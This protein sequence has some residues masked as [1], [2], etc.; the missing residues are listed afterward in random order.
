MTSSKFTDRR[1]K[2]KWP[3]NFLSSASILNSSLETFSYDPNPILCAAF[4]FRIYR[5]PLR[6]RLR[7]RL[8]LAQ[9]DDY[10]SAASSPFFTFSTTVLNAKP[11]FGSASIK[12]LRSAIGPRASY[13]LSSSGD[14]CK[15]PASF[16][17]ISS[18][19][20]RLPSSMSERKGLEMSIWSRQFAQG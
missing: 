9:L 20:K 18:E 7:S 19:G 1:T 14:T 3:R 4:L 16:A 6:S 10:S 17:R 13:C 12:R 5:R 8:S 15:A 2:A 11:S